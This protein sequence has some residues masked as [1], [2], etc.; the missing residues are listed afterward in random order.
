[1]SS[2]SEMATRCPDMIVAGFNSEHGPRWQA[3]VA[4]AASGIQL[5]PNDAGFAVPLIR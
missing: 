2:L 3:A 1:M 5:A 4:Q